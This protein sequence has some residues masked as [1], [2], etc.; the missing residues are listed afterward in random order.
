MRLTADFGCAVDLIVFYVVVVVVAGD[1]IMFFCKN[2]TQ[3]KHTHKRRRAGQMNI[4]Y[5]IGL[6]KMGFWVDLQ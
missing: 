4:V 3:N 6:V 1:G 5:I 2:N